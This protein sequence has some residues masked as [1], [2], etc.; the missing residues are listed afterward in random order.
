MHE[1]VADTSCPNP[2]ILW[3]R[4]GKVLVNNLVMKVDQMVASLLLPHRSS[5][6]SVQAAFRDSSLLLSS[7]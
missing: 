7:T 2:S 4:G 6:H 5:S 3:Y 1:V